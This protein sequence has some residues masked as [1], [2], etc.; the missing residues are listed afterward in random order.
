MLE[1]NQVLKGGQCDWRSQAGGSRYMTRLPHL[2]R[3]E[4]FGLH[5]KADGKPG[6]VSQ[7]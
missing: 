1:E 3:G 4:E 5:S 2:Y 6:Q 7:G